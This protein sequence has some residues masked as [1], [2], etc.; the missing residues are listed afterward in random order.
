MDAD[1][2]I[3]GG[4]P[5]A[6]A[7]TLDHIALLEGLTDEERRRLAIACR[8]R[9][10]APDQQIIDR[11]ADSREISF[12]VSGAVRVVNFSAQGREI[13]F[14]DIAAGGSVGELAAIDGGPRSAGVFALTETLVAQLDHRRFRAL[15]MGHPDVALGIMRKL[16]CMVREASRRI[17]DLS[18]LSAHNRVHGELLRLARRAA[19]AGGIADIDPLPNHADIAARVSTTR[20]TVAR[21]LG[22]LARD[23]LVERRGRALRVGDVGRLAALVDDPEPPGCG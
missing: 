8:W 1:L 18:T 19:A 22:D 13:S 9:R 4:R 17:M 21:V 11:D 15:I 10:Y 12:I 20:E 6:D 3:A 2:A 14:A 16:A 7:A 5:K 23:G